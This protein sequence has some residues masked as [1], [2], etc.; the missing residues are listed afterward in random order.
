[1]KAGLWAEKGNANELGVAFSHGVRGFQRIVA[2]KAVGGFRGGPD[3]FRGG[4]RVRRSRAAPMNGDFI[5]ALDFRPHW[6]C[7]VAKA[8]YA[9]LSYGS[10]DNGALC[11]HT[12]KSI[13]KPYDTRR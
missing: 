13:G 3:S 2:E 10:L 5:A 11:R 12:L 9:A 7:R 8:A 4:F 6:R 1:M